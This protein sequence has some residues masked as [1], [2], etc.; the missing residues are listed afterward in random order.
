[1]WRT[2]VSAER[3]RGRSQSWLRRSALAI[4]ATLLVVGHGQAAPLPPFPPV[5]ICGDIVSTS[6]KPGFELPGKPGFSGSLGHDRAFPA[7]FNVVIEHYSG[8]DARAA[9]R[10]NGLLSFDAGQAGGDPSQLLLII[11]S[12]DPDL[13]TRARSLCVYGYTIR[14]DEGGTWTSHRTLV[15]N[16]KG[17]AS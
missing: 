5:D 3:E 12:P 15:V 14:G 7:R 13:L 16:P 11:A 8:I 6:W 4:L 10:I 1:M 2:V 17:S 9:A